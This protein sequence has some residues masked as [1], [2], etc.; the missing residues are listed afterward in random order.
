MK[1]TPLL[2]S[3]LNAY[4]ILP[5]ANTDTVIDISTDG[6]YFYV[7]FENGRVESIHLR[8]LLGL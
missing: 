6:V 8:F 1:N 5:H 2:T 7:T 4:M 3:A